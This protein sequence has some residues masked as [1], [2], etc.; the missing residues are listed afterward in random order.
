[1]EYG[2]TFSVDFD[3]DKFFYI[4][5]ELV[6]DDYLSQTEVAKSDIRDLQVL[7]MF[8]RISLSAQ[9]ACPGMKNIAYHFHYP[10]FLLSAP[11]LPFVP[12]IECHHPSLLSHFRSLHRARL[13]SFLGESPVSGDYSLEYLSLSLGWTKLVLQVLRLLFCLFVA[14]IAEA[15]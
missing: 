13:H 2:N 15:V 14:F 10:N 3:D 6:C 4:S 9:S 12:G 11:Q 7:Q 8:A 1:M 5:S